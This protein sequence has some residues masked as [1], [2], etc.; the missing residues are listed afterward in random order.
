LNQKGNVDALRVAETP[1]QFN[2]NLNEALRGKTRYHKVFGYDEN[3]KSLMS[4]TPEAIA[5]SLNNNNV[6][7]A[8]NSFTVIDWHH[9]IFEAEQNQQAQDAEWLKKLLSI[10]PNSILKIPAHYL[11]KTINNSPFHS[12]LNHKFYI[13]ELYGNENPYLTL[14]SVF[15]TTDYPNETN[16]YTASCPKNPSTSKLKQ[17]LGDN[18]FFIEKTLNSENKGYVGEMKSWLD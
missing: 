7:K 6:L 13:I 3:Y 10:V 15:T 17:I 8:G 9:N 14:E 11:C 12:L 16:G 18:K 4:N 1:Y 5:S 2:I